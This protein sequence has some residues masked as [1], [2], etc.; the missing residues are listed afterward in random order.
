LTSPSLDFPQVILDIEKEELG[1]AAGLQDRVIQTYGG[2][3]HMDFTKLQS[4]SRGVYTP[5]DA[6]LLPE[7]Y[8][9]YNTE[10]GQLSH[11]FTF[12]SLSL[13]LLLQAE[14]LARYIQMQNPNG[15]MATPSLL[16]VLSFLSHLF[17]LTTSLSLSLSV[18]LSVSLTGMIALGHLADRAKECLINGDTKALAI[19]MNQNF[20]LRRELYGDDVVGRKNIAVAT[21]ANELGFACKFSGSGGAFV[22]LAKDG[23]GWLPMEEEERIR[24]EF[25]KEGFEFVRIESLV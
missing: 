20:Q 4:D 23:N 1:I 14:T 2:I 19:L 15:L 24:A 21:R 17:Y 9:L 3:V 13:L 12:P 8:L 22:C 10:E 5:L 16:L 18:S 11:S 7:L 6:S 25:K